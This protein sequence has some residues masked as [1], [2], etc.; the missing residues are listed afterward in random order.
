MK[1]VLS[2]M[3][4]ALVSRATT[5]FI[6]FGFLLIYVGIA[7]FS[8]EPLLTLLGLSARF[9]LALLLALLPLNC[10]ARLI[11]ELRC[12]RTGRAVRSGA[13]KGVVS[14]ELYDESCRLAGG[15]SL[16]L[17]QER[18]RSSGYRM[19]VASDSL[20]A[21]RGI[22]LA[23]ARLLL[24][25]ALC[26]LFGGVFL[27]VTLR[28]A[29]RITVIE[30][31]P[32]PQAGGGKVTRV[33]LE[34]YDGLF[35][36]RTI[37]IEVTEADGS[38]Q[39]G[40]YPPSLYGGRFVYPRYLGV[41]PL[42]RF[43]APD[44]PAGFETYFLLGIYPPGKEDSATIPGSPYRIFFTMVNPDPANDPLSSG[45]FILNF[46]IMEGDA[47]VASGSLPMGGS[48]AR[49]NYR[50]AVPDFRRTVAVDLVRD[51]GV[52]LIWGATALLIASLCWWLP[53]R[54]FA[55]RR[56]MH[57]VELDGVITAYS[58]AEGA[59]I[60]HGGLFHDALDFIDGSRHDGTP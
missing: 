3:V 37:A 50:L 11:L 36:E 27:S 2:L 30:G 35:L 7:F 12:I 21:W 9:P 23:P 55:P 4:A 44:L 47:Q 45:R 13:A 51:Y 41:A 40:L 46:R 29:Q 16:E 10:A 1:R 57:F 20:A 38:R 53:V 26:L 28:T 25:A 19:R 54:I 5:P 8:P 15:K 59:K 18:L 56:E 33:A 6:L 52:F 34:E 42:L 24:L 14:E 58:S 43:A 49:G 17:L 31:E 22:S 48:W 39:F 60:R 32:F